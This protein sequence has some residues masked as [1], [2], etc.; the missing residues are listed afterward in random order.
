MIFILD[1]TNDLKEEF[2]KI[3]K[4]GWVKSVR[5][6]SGGVG[7]TFEYLLGKEEENF[8]I[9][10]YNGIEIKTKRLSSLY[11]TSLFNARPDGKY[12]HE[13]E[14]LRDEYGYLDSFSKK[15]KVLNFTVSSNRITYVRSGF[16]FKLRIDKYKQKI[17]LC[18]FDHFGNLI[19]DFVYWDFDTLEEKLY[20]KLRLLA[21]IKASRRFINGVEYFH[22]TEMKLY[23]LK[24][25]DMFINLVE[26][27]KI[28]IKIEIG[29]FRS[30][31]RKG[32]IHDHGTTFAIKECDLLY[33]Y[34]LH[35]SK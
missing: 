9:P 10:D 8:E 4:M 21:F 1:Q 28:M 19:E 27:G 26:Q 11:E 35:S 14:R 24:S 29:V 3:K 16:A 20:R 30:G 6:G 22:Y 2:F 32:Q 13:I 31:K 34:N 25:F 33:L 23:S 5:K 7:R 17:F 15:Y 18:V 12:F